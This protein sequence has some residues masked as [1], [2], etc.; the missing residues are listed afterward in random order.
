[1]ERQ[2][3]KKLVKDTVATLGEIMHNTAIEN[4]RWI[5]A[6]TEAQKLEA[7]AAEKEGLAKHLL[8][9]DKPGDMFL[10]LSEYNKTYNLPPFETQAHFAVR[11]LNS[12]VFLLVANE[13]L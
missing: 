4:T 8:T 2:D 9:V 5:F 6:L 3:V 7:F 11:R 12:V 10:F 13:E 1:M